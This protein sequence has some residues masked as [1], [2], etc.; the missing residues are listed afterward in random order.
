MSEGIDSLSGHRIGFIGCGA[1]AQALA[2]GLVAAGIP[3]KNLRGADLAPEQRKQFEAGTGVSA[4][5]ANDE[6]VVS[7]DVIVVCVKPNVV[8]TVLADLDGTPGLDEKLWISLAAGIGLTTYGRGLPDATRVI[9]SMPNTPALV[10]AGATALCPNAHASAADLEVAEALFSAVGTTWIT[11]I[12]DQLDAVTGLS[13]SGPAYVFL[14]LEALGDA[15]VR[16]GLPRDAAYQLA[17]QTVLGAAKLAIESGEDPGVL[18]DRVSSP[19][20]TTI[21]GLEEL[22]SAGVRA[23]IHAAVAAA[24]ARSKQLGSKDL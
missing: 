10:G 12:E 5:A 13:G 24:T 18:K 2:G 3:T 20:G 14:I 1:M 16:Q 22:E 21:A 6:L 4:T 19:G 11:R 8:A 23:A 9:R 7:C 15:G 17:C